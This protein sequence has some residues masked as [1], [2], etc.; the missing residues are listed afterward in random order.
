MVTVFHISVA[1]LYAKS[2]AI[3]VNIV[4]HEQKIKAQHIIDKEYKH[5][6][7]RLVIFGILK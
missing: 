4:A 6:Q 2:A 7:V 1:V 5:S 3:D